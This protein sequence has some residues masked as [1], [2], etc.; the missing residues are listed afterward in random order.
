[1]SYKSSAVAIGGV[2]SALCLLFMFLT[3]V[4][5]FATF[6]LP[7]VAGM[8]LI[9]VVVE[10]G[11][12]VAFCVYVAVSLLSLVMVPDREAAMMFIGFFGYYVIIKGRLDKI[13]SRFVR[14]STKLVIFNTAVICSYLII[15]FVFGLT[16]LL[17]ADPILGKYAFLI[18]LIPANLV[19]AVYDLAVK[20]VAIAYIYWF[21][22]K[23]LRKF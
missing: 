21:R 3:G 17:E 1:M 7:A 20:R 12:K 9:A 4:M 18:L 14:I 2:A 19:F 5:P 11:Y 10:N 8:V 22:P 23:F 16:E 6:A 13:K 15:I